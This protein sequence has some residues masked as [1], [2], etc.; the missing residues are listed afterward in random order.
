MFTDTDDLILEL[1]DTMRDWRI[2]ATDTD[3]FNVETIGNA[4]VLDVDGKRF[5]ITVV[6]VV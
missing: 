4:I 1:E 6:E 2:D 3:T 5:E